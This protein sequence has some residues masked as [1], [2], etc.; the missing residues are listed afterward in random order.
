MGLHKP[1]VKGSQGGF[2]EMMFKLGLEVKV[3]IFL[4]DLAWRVVRKKLGRLD[5]A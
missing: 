1:P 5:N 4:V 2:P 3:R